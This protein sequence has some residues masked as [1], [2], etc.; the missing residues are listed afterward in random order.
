MVGNPRESA[1]RARQ[2]RNAEPVP[3]HL[4]MAQSMAVKRSEFNRSLQRL[5]PL[6]GIGRLKE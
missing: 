6:I 1:R 2:H 5:R 3:A 4:I